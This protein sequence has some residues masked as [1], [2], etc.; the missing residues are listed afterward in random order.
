MNEQSLSVVT[1]SFNNPI[2]WK[3]LWELFREFYQWTFSTTVFAVFIGNF[4]MIFSLHSTSDFSG[5]S[6]KKKSTKVNLLLGNLWIFFP[7][8]S[9][10]IPLE[11]S[12][13]NPSFFR[14][15]SENWSKNVYK[16]SSSTFSWKFSEESSMH[17]LQTCLKKPSFYFLKISSSDFSW[18]STKE[19]Y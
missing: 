2:F 9:L 16:K 7:Q 8:N 13:E 1:E 3:S 15:F 11:I 5:S 17:F 12:L 6:S 4:F 19:Y 14:T 10:K 18:K